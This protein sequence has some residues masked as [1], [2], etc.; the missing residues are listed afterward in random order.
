[1]ACARCKVE[2]PEHPK[3]IRDAFLNYCLEYMGIESVSYQASLCQ[4]LLR[5]GLAIRSLKAE[6]D[7]LSRA[8]T[9]SVRYENGQMYHRLGQ[10]WVNDAEEELVTFPTGM[11]DDMVDTVTYAAI[12]VSQYSEHLVREL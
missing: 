8:I 7:K 12:E 10:Q 1:M 5:E 2:G 6:T 3:L 11:H 4:T 9:A